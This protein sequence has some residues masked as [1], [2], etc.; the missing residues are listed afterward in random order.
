MRYPDGRPDHIED[1]L[2]SYRTGQ[3]YTFSDNKIKFTQIL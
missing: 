1:F 3:W 2:A